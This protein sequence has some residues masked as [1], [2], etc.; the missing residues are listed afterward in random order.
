MD[1]NGGTAREHRNMGGPKGEP[2]GAQEESSSRKGTIGIS[3]FINGVGDEIWVIRDTRGFSEEKGPEFIRESTNTARLTNNT[4]WLDD[5]TIALMC[6]H[7]NPLTP[8][9]RASAH[10]VEANP[11]TAIVCSFFEAFGRTCIIVQAQST[12]TVQVG[13]DPC[14]NGRKKR[15][16]AQCVARKRLEALLK[17]LEKE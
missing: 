10:L 4:M 5:Q 11:N 9:K 2:R 14:F 6:E 8:V 17:V 12:G 7:V 3:G 1:Q 13:D 15:F 16:C